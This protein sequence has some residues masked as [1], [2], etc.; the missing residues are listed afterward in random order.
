MK[1]ILSI[2]LAAV[3][4]LSM[5]ACSN[6][7]EKNEEEG[8]SSKGNEPVLALEIEEETAKQLVSERLNTEVYSVEA[9]GETE[10]N[11][12]SYYVFKVLEGETELS[13]GVAVN[14]T[15]GELYAYKEDKTIAPYEEFTLYDEEKDAVINWEGEFE[16][17]K[18][19]IK[20][21]PAD[22][23]SF[24]F[25]ILKTKEDS[26]PVLIGVAMADG[27]KAVYESDGKVIEF[28]LNEELLTLTDKSTDKL[29][30]DINGNFKL[31]K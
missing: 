6:G 29:E 14:K 27:N 5:A 15:S 31:I 4:V 13:M 30:L 12:E 19:V 7:K 3:M 24:E 9:N 18:A 11:G 8:D 23:G 21:I 17:D 20:L 26:E 28:E 22:E 10:E 25:Q 2:C 16:S 1:K